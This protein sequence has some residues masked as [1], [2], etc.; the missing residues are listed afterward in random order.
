LQQDG[1]DP[2]VG[3]PQL[4]IRAKADGSGSGWL[5]V[6]TIENREV[7]ARLRDAV[8]KAW[9]TLDDRVPLPVRGRRLWS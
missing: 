4:P 6:V 2:W 8:L 7:M 9:Q 5:P 1:G 3:L